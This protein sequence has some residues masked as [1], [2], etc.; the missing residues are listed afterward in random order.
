MVG[1]WAAGGPVIWSNP[2]H[3]TPSVKWL[4]CRQGS[5]ISESNDVVAETEYTLNKPMFTNITSLYILYIYI[6]EINKF[7]YHSLKSCQVK[8]TH[9]T[10]QGPCSWNQ[11][12]WS[13]S[14]TT[15]WSQYLQ[16]RQIHKKCFEYLWIVPVHNAD[17]LWKRGSVHQDLSMNSTN[18]HTPLG[19]HNDWRQFETRLPQIS[20]E[21]YGVM[22]GGR[23][24]SCKTADLKILHGHSFIEP[25]L[26]HPHFGLVKLGILY[27]LAMKSETTDL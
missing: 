17:L 18:I 8:Q 14:T 11:V 22:Y 12:T 27:T 5:P 26:N 13:P 16:Q 6:L 24:L 19:T 23:E 20:Y 21:S 3:W 2:G 10:D 7:T 9:P 25:N 4:D 15:P 1:G